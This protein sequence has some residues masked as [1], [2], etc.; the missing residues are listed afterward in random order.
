M[1]LCT[2]HGDAACEQAC[3][4]ALSL[5]VYDVTRIGRCLERNA[6][7]TSAL[8]ASPASPAATPTPTPTP[9]L[10]RFARPMQEF[11]RRLKAA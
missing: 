6:G 3:K 11:V 8:P 2:I 4:L 10:P 7:A 1:K 9:T 5:E